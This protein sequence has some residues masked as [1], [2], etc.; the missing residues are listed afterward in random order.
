VACPAGEVHLETVLKDLQT[1][2][3]RVALKV[4][5]PL[6]AFRESVFHPPEQKDV[7]PKPVKVGPTK[8]VL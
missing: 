3:A 2:F 5:P 6:V 8:K 1:R 4:S 7:I